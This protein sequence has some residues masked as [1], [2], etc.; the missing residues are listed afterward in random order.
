MTVSACLCSIIVSAYMY[1]MVV[2][3]YMWVIVVSAYV[4]QCS[5]LLIVVAVSLIIY[6]VSSGECSLSADSPDDSHGWVA[7]LSSNPTVVVSVSGHHN[8][9]L[10]PPSCSPAVTTT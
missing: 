2:F 6:L 10:H 5:C 1:V 3:S 7:G 8:I 9:A 4:T